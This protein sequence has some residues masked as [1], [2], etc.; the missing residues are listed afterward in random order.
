MVKVIYNGVVLDVLE[1]SAEITFA[2]NDFMNLQVGKPYKSSELTLPASPVNLTAI[3]ELFDR[4]GANRNRTLTNV[5]FDIGLLQING[6]LVIYAQQG[7]FLK[8]VFVSGNAL[9]W[10][11]FRDT[12]LNQLN[13]SEFDYTLSES[14]ISMAEAGTLNSLVRYDLCDRGKMIDDPVVSIVERFPLFHLDTMFTK[15]FEKYNV[16]SNFRSADWWQKLY[17]LYTG[18]DEIQNTD[19]WKTS[20]L[21]KAIGDCSKTY[22]SPVGVNGWR[23]FSIQGVNAMVDNGRGFDNGNNFNAVSQVYVVPDDGTYRFKAKVNIAVDLANQSTG[24]PSLRFNSAGGKPRIYLRIKNNGMVV[25]LDDT[26]EFTLTGAG[27]VTAVITVDTD[28]LNFRQADQVTFEC[29]VYGQWLQDAM[30]T[31]LRGQV[32][33]K[34]AEFYN[35]VSRMYGTFSDV[36]IYKLMPDV[37]V[38]DWLND[39]F[40]HF[41]IT[42][43]YSPET[44]ILRLN[45]YARSQSIEDITDNIDSATIEAEF[46]DP[47][48]YELRFKADSSDVFAE[49]W[50]KTNMQNDG[51]YKSAD[52][53]STKKIIQSAFSNTV[54]RMPA[55]LCGITTVKIP[56]LW[57][58]LESTD[59]P[60]PGY[61]T[62]FNY[63]ILMDMGVQDAKYKFAY[64][65]AVTTDRTCG[66]VIED[67]DVYLFGVYDAVS[68]IEFCN[69]G[70]LTGLHDRLH[71]SY[72]ERIIKGCLV[73]VT[74]KISELHLNNIVN[75]AVQNITS[76]VYLGIQNYE[77][78][79]QIQ[80]IT[81]DGEETKYELIR[82]ED[83]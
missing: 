67:R 68:T 79:Y 46:T 21:F 26:N 52:L 25:A 18:T 14:T 81:T 8:A 20:A 78:V 56:F 29:G 63:R 6:N 36:E 35:S 5:L 60:V 66:R 45:T 75:N 3:G 50:F 82:A 33:D 51:N 2:Y 74:G 4:T 16:E 11:D 62:N 47:F 12:K 48:S 15:I 70:T 44:N 42:S 80:S 77:G 17:L 69:R 64:H 43:V 31:E 53:G 61:K 13:W 83:Y 19:E 32:S 57:S 49:N 54:M 10:V 23:D 58:A 40:A 39:I 27:R 22:T 1:T 55:R 34:V 30:N 71:K 72:M 28:F 76:P 24:L 73:T 41:A 59:E 65:V 38:N 37:R 9:A 7:M